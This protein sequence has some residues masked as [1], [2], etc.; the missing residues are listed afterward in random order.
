VTASLHLLLSGSSRGDGLFVPGYTPKPDENM[1][2]KVMPAGTNFFETMRI[3]ILRGRDFKD[4]DNEAAPKVA[5]VNE[6]L[7][8]RFFG[9]RDPIGQ[10]IGWD[11]SK[12]DLEIVGVVKDAK[13]DSLRRDVPPTVYHPFLQTPNLAWM[14]Y[15]VRTKGDPKTLIPGVRSVVAS[16]NRNVPIFDLKTQSE[17]IDE[18]LLQ[19][20]LFAKLAGF[21]GLLA[22]ALACVGLYGIMSYAVARRTGEIGIRMALGAQRWNILRMILRETLILVGTGVAL[23]I[24]ASLATTRYAASVISG[25]LYGLKVTDTSTVAIAAAILILVALFAGFL[26]ARRASRVDPM[27]ALRYE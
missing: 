24:P 19:E 2:V 27:V 21:F 3:P 20:R 5:V 7:V 22:L 12:A 6:T 23:G 25:L 10:H 13:Y 18:L 8:R 26:P 14:H 4:N 16:L 11:P 17:Q 15:E 9:D 1:S